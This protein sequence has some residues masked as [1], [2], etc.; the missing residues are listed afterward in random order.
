VHRLLCEQREDRGA[1]VAA[2]GAAA[3]GTGAAVTAVATPMWA[4]YE[5]DAYLVRAAVTG[6]CECGHVLLPW[7]RDIS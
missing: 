1:D 2:P 4:A 6:M 3:E 5:V 7:Y